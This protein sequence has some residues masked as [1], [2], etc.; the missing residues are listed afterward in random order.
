MK[1]GNEC[2]HRP[3]FPETWAR[4][5]GKGRVFYTSMGHRED[6]W[7]NPMYQGLLLGALNWATGQVD[8]DIKPNTS[9]VTPH[10]EEAD[11]R[12]IR[13]GS[14]AVERGEAHRLAA[15]PDGASTRVTAPYDDVTSP[16]RPRPRRWSIRE[17]HPS[18]PAA[19]E[20][21]TSPASASSTAQPARIFWVYGFPM[22]LAIGLGLAF[23]SPAAPSVL[24]DLVTAR[25][26]ATPGPVEDPARREGRGE[27]DRRRSR[28]A[29]SSPAGTR[30]KL[31]MRLVSEAEGERRIKT[32]K[33]GPSW[34]ARMLGHGPLSL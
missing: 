18:C 8:A 6:V 26:S 21:C 31:E 2:Y 16:R 34:S 7:E 14:G 1:G 4:M 27:G 10:F 9:V 25:A 3:N 23:K 32:G 15:M 24:V 13:P 19:S 12:L 22:V 29:A 17:S 5:H 33:T 11:E 28:E 20:S 30:P